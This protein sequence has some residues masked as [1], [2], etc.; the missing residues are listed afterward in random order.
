MSDW[1]IIYSASGEQYVAEAVASARSSLRFNHVPHLIY[2]D[3]RPVERV[4]GVEFIA[5]SRTAGGYLAKIVDIGRMPFHR[6]LFLDT[7]TYVTS[8]VGE[9]FELL[10][11]FD[12]AAAPPPVY[13][14]APDPVGSEAFYDLNTGVLALR[15]SDRL[16][17]VLQRWAGLHEEWALVA[18]PFETTATDQ[19]AFRRVLWES[20]LSLY[21]LGPEYNYRSVFPGRLVGAAKIIHGR[22]P[23]FEA[24]ASVLNASAGQPR[25]FEMFPSRAEDAAP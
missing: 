18:A 16:G 19:H 2:C 12:L 3:A 22:S 6:T 17:E 10:D 4:E 5:R 21:V 15:R 20:D 11:R 25:T 14:K 9:L 7:D 23:D 1:G 8:C 24:L 13:T